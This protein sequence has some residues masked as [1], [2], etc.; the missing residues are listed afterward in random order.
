MGFKVIN[1][2]VCGYGVKGKEGR[3]FVLDCTS[4]RWRRAY[5]LRATWYY[6]W[7]VALVYRINGIRLTVRVQA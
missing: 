6:W 7:R 2:V 3:R 4:G 5:G 1:R